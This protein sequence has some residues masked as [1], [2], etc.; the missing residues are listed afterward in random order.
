MNSL[1]KKE[2]N[3]WPLSSFEKLNHLS[4]YRTTQFFLIYDHCSFLDVYNMKTSSPN[5]NGGAIN[6]GFIKDLAQVYL[7]LSNSILKGTKASKHGGAVAIAVNN[8]IN[9]KNCTFEENRADNQKDSGSSLLEEKAD[10]RGGAIFICTKYKDKQVADSLIIED[11]TFRKNAAFDDYGIYI[12]GEEM[13]TG[14]TSIKNN[15]FFDN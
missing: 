9:I 7:T 2:K 12:D 11:C 8:Q 5:S 15:K 4:T 3:R 1:R 14:T 13:P 6:F 10:G